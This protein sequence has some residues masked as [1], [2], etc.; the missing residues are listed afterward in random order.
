MYNIEYCKFQEWFMNSF[1]SDTRL[2]PMFGV[3]NLQY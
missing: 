3:Q 1:D 2:H